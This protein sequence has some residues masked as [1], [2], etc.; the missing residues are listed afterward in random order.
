MS[1]SKARLRAWLTEPLVHFVAAG[2]VLFVASH[3]RGKNDDAHK[4]VITPRRE[5]QLA[6][7]YAMQ[8]G[9]PPSSTTM[10]QLVEEEIEQEILFRRGVALGLDRDDEIVRR[11]VVQKMQF[12]LHDVQ[13]PPEPRQAELSAYFDQ[14]EQRYW[15]P[16]R[17]TFS[18]V[19]FSSNEGD[20]VARARARHA[21]QRA[22]QGEDASSLGDSFPD[23]HHFAAYEPE[24]VYRLFGRTELAAA[25]FAVP[26][27]GWMGPYRSS[28]GWHLVRVEARQESQRPTFAEVSDRVRTDYLSD[29][30]ARRNLAAFNELASEYQ[31]IRTKL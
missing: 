2:L 28:F 16:P 23:L 14:H 26:V 17:V 29:E 9:A 25:T 21:L 10:S 7:R 15:S 8:F 19:Y 18:H 12:L 22:I 3:L 27:G 4:I 30:Q 1:K 5:A 11:R 13:A 24:Q 20:D 6:N 31:V